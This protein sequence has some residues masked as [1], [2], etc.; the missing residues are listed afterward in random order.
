MAKAAMNRGLLEEANKHSD[1]AR[2]YRADAEKAQQTELKVQQ[3]TW[4]DVKEMSRLMTNPQTFQQGIS[5]LK[6][7]YPEFGPRQIGLT[8]DLDGV[9]RPTPQNMQLAGAVNQIA[10]KTKDAIDQTQRQQ[11]IAIRQA[12]LARKTE[13]DAQID[14]YKDQVLALRRDGME[15]QAKVLEARMDALKAQGE[16][17]KAKDQESVTKAVQRTLD[18]SPAYANYDKFNQANSFANNVVEELKTTKD[19]TLLTPSQAD[20]LKQAYV[21]ASQGFRSREGKWSDKNVD[22]FNGILQ[23]A[24]KFLAT[25]GGGTPALSRKTALEVADSINKLHAI[26]TAESFADEAAAVTNAARRGGDPEGLTLRAY[27]PANREMLLNRGLMK[28]TEFWPG[29]KW[30][31]KLSVAG[32]EFEVDKPEAQ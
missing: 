18:K 21:S 8:P 9:F 6:A 28:V 23:R 27:T 29:T 12:E 14:Q 11:E 3:A 32:R 25:P 31:K 13:K 24:E 15:Q 20:A 1:N 10:V 7:K 2:L 5:I 19:Y 26:A 16:H 4:G 22:A 17:N 30:A